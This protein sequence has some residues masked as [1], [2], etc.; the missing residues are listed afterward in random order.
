[1]AFNVDNL[2]YARYNNCS[3]WKCELKPSE[4]ACKIFFNYL[5]LC[6]IGFFTKKVHFYHKNTLLSAF[7]TNS[8]N[9]IGRNPSMVIPLL[10][11]QDL[12]PILL[13]LVHRN[14]LCF[15]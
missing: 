9:I 14:T 4:L 12:T 1:M 13:L 10:T 2:I 8:H 3:F 11:N 15:L 6:V 5:K 7:R